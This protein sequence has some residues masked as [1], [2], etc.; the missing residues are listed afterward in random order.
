MADLSVLIGVVGLAVA[1]L[2]TKLYPEKL[3]YLVERNA[4]SGEE[5]RYVRF[6]TLF[7]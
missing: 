4:N 5:T 3:T 2:L 1:R 7:S 6:I